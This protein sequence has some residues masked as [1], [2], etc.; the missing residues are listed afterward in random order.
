[1]K[2]LKFILSGAALS[3]ASV[4]TAAPNLV[5][6][7]ADIAARKAVLDDPKA[8][9]YKK[10]CAAFALAKWKLLTCE[11]AD[12]AAAKAEAMKLVTDRG[13]LS[14]GDYVDFLYMVA[15]REASDMLQLPDIDE[16][17]D[18]ATKGGSPTNR[19]DCQARRNYYSRRIGAIGAAQRTKSLNPKRSA[20]VRLALVDAAE[21]EPLLTGY[22]GEVAAW[23][24]EA[25][26]SDGKYDEAEKFAA[27]LSVSTNVQ[28][29]AE[30]SY[31]LGAF[32]VARA[33]RYF[34]EPDA[35]TLKKA[36]AAY[37]AAIAAAD[38]P[39]RRGPQY[40]R[41]WQALGPIRLQLKD[42]AGVREVADKLDEMT[43]EKQRPNLTAAGLRG[44][45]AFAERKWE[46]AAK[47]YE[48][49]GEKHDLRQALNLAKCYLALG[50]KADAVPLLEFASKKGNKYTR[51]R[52]AFDLEKLKGEL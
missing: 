47:A 6:M 19:V 23:R 44:D 29:A 52:Y 33:A 40:S 2:T 13:A 42:Y 27:P 39:K 41:G 35:A 38:Q 11:D 4:L 43:G 24:Y 28:T 34:D 17:A 32:Y 7:D 49:V 30:W 21:K 48:I 10:H 45:A 3:A 15:E 16:L 50:R 9:A 37:L 5:T 12:Y 46:E 20:A 31:R 18:A 36:E 22:A 51:Q 14:N 25:L 1:M 8:S 26:L